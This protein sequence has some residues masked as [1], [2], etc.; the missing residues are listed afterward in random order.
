MATLNI[1]LPEAMKAFIEEEAAR[2]GFGTVSEYLR[3]IIRDIQEQQTRR[4][5]I[6][7]LLLEGLDSGPATTMT[8]ADWEQIRREVHRR[9]LE[10]QE[11]AIGPQAPE[12]R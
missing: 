9:H 3:S 4:E 5:H 1:S 2:G 12:G 7:S 6:D 11:R 8:R 10:R